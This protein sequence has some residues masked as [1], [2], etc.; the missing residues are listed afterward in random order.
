MLSSFY[1]ILNIAENSKLEGDDE[2]TVTS[3][4]IL[5]DAFDFWRSVDM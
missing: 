5:K 4:F 1:D 2:F 3:T